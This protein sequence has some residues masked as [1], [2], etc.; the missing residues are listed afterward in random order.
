MD[1]IGKVDRGFLDAT[2]YAGLGADREDVR[3]GPGPGLDFGV[4]DVGE[5]VVAVAADPLFVPLELGVEPAAWYG[6]HIAVSDV[7]LSGLAPSHL[8]LTVTLPPGADQEQFG[9]VW[10]VIDEEARDA[11]IAITTGH[12]GRYE[13]C[14]YPYIGAATAFAVG[15]P[16]ALVVPAGA[17]PGDVLLVTNGPAIET[18]GVIAMRFGDQL[19]VDADVIDAA[20]DRF[21]EM[22]VLS[23]ARTAAATGGV[24]AMHD[25]TERGL[26]NA[27]HELAAAA[28]VGLDITRDHLPVGEGVDA[29]CSHLGIDPLTASSTGTVLLAAAPDDVDEL[30]AAFD[31]N[32][33]RAAPIGHVHD[34][35]GV[36]IDGDPLPEPETDPFWSVYTTLTERC[37]D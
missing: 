34:G 19:D 23:A 20:R 35:D 11:D 3:V 25:A 14:A 2:V 26:A 15:D 27:C 6:F 4:F 1:R 8:S 30:L 10:A 22:D 12:T 5:N 16:T 7:A 17:S 33:I 29:L 24:T 9:E 28:D 37:G 13:G 21:W 36:C 31:A 32:G 18:V